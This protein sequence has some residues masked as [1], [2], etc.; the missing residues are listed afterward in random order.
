VDEAYCPYFHHAIEVLGRRWAGAILHTLQEAG[1]CPFGV[2]RAS[3]PGLSDRL[4][5]ERLAELESEKIVARVE[6]ADSRTVYTL[7]ERGHA[8][9]PVFDALSQWA[10]DWLVPDGEPVK[11]GRSRLDVV[12][13]AT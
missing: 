4:L 3:V 5:V 7:T 1:P 9:R 13:P 8:L 12:K 6:S 10:V 2:L 11:P